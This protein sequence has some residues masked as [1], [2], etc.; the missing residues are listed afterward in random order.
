MTTARV[1]QIVF[2]RERMSKTWSGQGSED[3]FVWRIVVVTST[4]DRE[5]YGYECVDHR[6]LCGE[7]A[8]PRI[9]E[10]TERVRPIPN[11]NRVTKA[12]KGCFKGGSHDPRFRPGDFS[13]ETLQEAQTFVKQLLATTPTPS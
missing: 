3:L 7:G 1:G 8:H 9:R 2:L 5:V 12:M 6:E 13:F 11:G 10:V 4:R